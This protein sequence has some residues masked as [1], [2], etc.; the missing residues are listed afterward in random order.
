[1]I[2]VIHWKVLSYR[3]VNLNWVRLRKEMQANATPC[4]RLWDPYV[5]L[6][7]SFRNKIYVTLSDIK[8]MFYF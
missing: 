3:E 4:A 7:I 1:V 5:D 8:T 2:L 6:C